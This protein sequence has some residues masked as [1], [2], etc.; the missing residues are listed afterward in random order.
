MLWHHRHDARLHRGG[1]TRPSVGECH[2][3]GAGE[4]WNVLDER[5][6]ARAGWRAG[7]DSRIGRNKAVDDPGGGKGDGRDQQPDGGHGAEGH[8]GMAANRSKQPATIAKEENTRAEIR[9]VTNRG[10][11]ILHDQ[12]YSNA[13]AYN[14]ARAEHTAC[15]ASAGVRSFAETSELRSRHPHAT[16]SRHV[17]RRRNYAGYRVKRL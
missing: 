17:R 10:G 2:G 14:D 3:R 13:T 7:V 5:Q 9:D 12:R 8:D 15:G 11:R 16:A 1:R 6:R 4:F